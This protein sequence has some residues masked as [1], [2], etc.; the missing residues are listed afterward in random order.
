MRD[1]ANWAIP[2]VRLFGVRLRIHLLYLLTVF[3][4]LRFVRDLPTGISVGE[5]FT[6]I[7]L[8]PLPI[9]LVHEW[10]HVAAARMLGGDA[11]SITI[12]P[13]G[14][15]T[16][17]IV[18]RHLRSQLAVAFAGPVA[19]LLLCLVLTSASVGSGYVPLVGLIT[20]PIAAPS[21][22]TAT[23]RTHTSATKP[24]YY[25][26]STLDKVGNPKFLDEGTAIDPELPGI[27]LDV[28]T[29]PP[30]VVWM[31]R[32]NWLSL[33][34]V[35]ANLAIAAV[36][37]DMGRVVQAIAAARREEAFRTALSVA[38][39]AFL[40]YIPCLVLVAIVINETMLVILAA[41]ILVASARLVS[42]S[43]VTSAS[44]SGEKDDSSFGYDFSQ[45]YTSLEKEDREDSSVEPKAEPKLSFW[46]KRRRARENDRLRIE[47]EQDQKDAERVDQLLDKIQQFGKASLTDEER[48][49]LERVS[50]K[51]RGPK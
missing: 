21:R 13:L 11:D 7:C 32:A 49:F 38:R 34:L 40:V 22:S 47:A 50:L 26:P 10:G 28:A 2:L 19:S 31:W 18:P 14:G 41:V 25:R 43:I 44:E 29:L 23:Q 24:T 48:Q 27:A 35:I 8:L 51:Y 4:W 45:G 3:V 16:S 12:W 15:M 20:D 5:L 1:P 30:S 46:E 33:W 42:Q 37:L 39:F 9:L 36:P 17:P 6:L